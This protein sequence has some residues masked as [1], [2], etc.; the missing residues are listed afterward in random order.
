MKVD[1]CNINVL[2]LLFLGTKRQIM[3]PR[4]PFKVQILRVSPH[5]LPCT[6]M[7]L[8][9]QH[10]CKLL[11]MVSFI[12]ASPNLANFPH[13]KPTAT[14]FPV[15]FQSW[16]FSFSP[17]HQAKP[18]VPFPHR[19]ALHRQEK[20]MLLILGHCSP[21]QGLSPPGREKWGRKLVSLPCSWAAA[22][23]PAPVFSK[24]AAAFTQL[25]SRG[26]SGSLGLCQA[27]LKEK[28]MTRE[29]VFIYNQLVRWKSGFYI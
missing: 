13:W 9:W 27:L 20:G 2:M 25:H 21:V 23:Q 7:V 10:T 24:F 8:P 5:Q 16:L 15:L 29:K 6:H 19:C 11:L 14:T 3:E 17:K 4:L 26:W 22:C 12:C 1:K 28:K 18:P